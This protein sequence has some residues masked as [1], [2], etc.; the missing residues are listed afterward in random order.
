MIA[1]TRKQRRALMRENLR[2]PE[3]LREVPR[4]Q[5]PPGAPDRLLKVWRSRDFLAQLYATAVPGV[6][7]LSVNR[8]VA[9]PSG[10]WD[11]GLSWDELQR[12]KAEAGFADRYAVEVYPAEV[13]T[14]NVANMRHLWLLPEPPAFAWRAP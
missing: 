10:R 13:D 7:R 2:Q 8:T 5:W 1:T 11:D 9:L 3:A 6:V 4:E 14:V 12:V